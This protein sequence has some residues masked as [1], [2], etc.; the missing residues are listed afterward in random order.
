MRVIF[1]I[2]MM[3]RRVRAPP[4]YELSSDSGLQVD[5]SEDCAAAVVIV[6]VRINV[7]FLVGLYEDHLSEWL[8]YILL[9]KLIAEGNFVRQSFL[10]AVRL[11]LAL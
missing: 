7:E 3:V 5:F 9:L 6:V 10:L 8:A 2:R 4:L 1:I 11:S